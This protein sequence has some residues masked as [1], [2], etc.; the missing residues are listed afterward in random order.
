MKSDYYATSASSSTYNFMQGRFVDISKNFASLTYDASLSTFHT[1]PGVGFIA[2]KGS[3]SINATAACLTRTE[4][5]IAG[6]AYRYLIDTG[7][8]N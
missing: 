7:R 5:A 6:L 4:R 2:Y 8:N 3:S 1:Q